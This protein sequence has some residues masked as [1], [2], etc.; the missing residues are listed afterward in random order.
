L[1]PQKYKNYKWNWKN[2]PSAH[3]L[4]EEY[5]YLPPG[6]KTA[7]EGEGRSGDYPR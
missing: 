2:A 6:V 1:S 5:W 4:V 3:H 7:K